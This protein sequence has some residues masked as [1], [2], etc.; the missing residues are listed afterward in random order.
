[1]GLGGP[2]LTALVG[3]AARL[4]LR[5]VSYPSGLDLLAQVWQA[6]AEDAHTLPGPGSITRF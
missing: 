1:M 6:I 2:R 5:R 3:I 4:A